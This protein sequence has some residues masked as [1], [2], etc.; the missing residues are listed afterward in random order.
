MPEN[1]Q[2]FIKPVGAACNL[3]CSYCYYLE[4]AKLYS[5]T[6]PLKMSDEV[7]ETLIKQQIEAST[8]EKV[9]FSWHGGEPLL[10]GIDFYRKAVAIQKKY[11]SGRRIALNGIQTNGTLLSEEWCKFLRDENFIIGISIDGPEE[12]HNRN[13]I[14]TAGKPTFREVMRGYNLLKKYEITSE[15]LCVVNSG[16]SSCPLEVYDFLRGLGA[17]FLTFL[18]MV[19][20]DGSGLSGVTAESVKPE[21]FGRFLIAI[22]DR[23]IENDIGKVKIQI[24]EEALRTAFNEDHTLCIFKVEC[25]GVPVVEHNGDFYSC[26][27]YVNGSHLIGNIMADPVVKILR[28]PRQVEFGEA[29]SRTLPRYCREC[30]VL[31][32]CNGECP[33]NRFAFSPEGEPGLNYLCPGYRQFFTHCKPF[34]EVLKQTWRGQQVKSEDQ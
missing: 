28:D 1:F 22:F 11:L 7:L 31:G 14:T 18:P 12:L 29:K 8:E 24:F 3:G 2:I 5:G 34:N 20:R 27:H 15:I 25:G 23:W 4:K 17:P 26:D 21:K 13:R 32:M 30:E 19:E 16:N 10:A 33:K 9:F 6:G